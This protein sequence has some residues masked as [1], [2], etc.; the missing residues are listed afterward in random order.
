[1]NGFTSTEPAPHLSRFIAAALTL[2]LF[3]ATI[4]TDPKSR[5][6]EKL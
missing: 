3:L 2:D 4:L 1:M 5:H 6:A